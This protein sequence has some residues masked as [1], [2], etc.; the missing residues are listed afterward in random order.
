[1]NDTEVIISL[2][3][4][5]ERTAFV[6]H[7]KKRNKRND[8]KN[9]QLFNALINGQ[10]DGIKSQMNSNAYNVLKK[11]FNGSYCRLYGRMHY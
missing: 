7:L 1:M 5:S 10:S 11:A 4:A 9:I 3:S 2:L 8:T 6:S